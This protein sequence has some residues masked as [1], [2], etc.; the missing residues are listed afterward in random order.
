MSL[1]RFLSSLPYLI[2]MG[3]V[4][5]SMADIGLLD[6]GKVVKGVRNSVTF[7]TFLFPPNMDVLA[8]VSKAM[9]ETVQIALVGTVLGFILA[10]P[11]SLL[12]T[13]SLYG[14]AITV[15]VRTVLSVVRTI[16]SLL[17]AIIFVVAF[18][19]GPAA[20]AL[21]VAFYTVGYLGK[22]FY[23]A[24]DGVDR[25]VIDAVW[26]SGA[27]RLQLARFAVLPEAANHILSQLLFI[28]EYNVRASAILG[29]VG[30]GGIGFYMMGYVQLLQYGSLLTALLVTLAVVLVIDQASAW[31]RARVLPPAPRSV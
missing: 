11:L 3:I 12:A 8:T 19:L 30:A 2:V 21:G 24:L 25:E 9:V 10:L 27:N 14:R 13:R 26:S 31:I 6:P 16:P 15:G 5:A 1:R 29:F 28:F 22:L 20:G 23:E 4:L 17:W 18:G 7:G